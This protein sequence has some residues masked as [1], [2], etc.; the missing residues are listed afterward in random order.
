MVARE[1]AA[2]VFPLISPGSLGLMDDDEEVRY[3]AQIQ[4]TVEAEFERARQQL[5]DLT[6]PSGSQEDH[7]AVLTYLRDIAD[8]ARRITDAAEANDHAALPSLYDESGRPS[9]ALTRALS[10]DGKAVFRPLL[11]EE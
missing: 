8:I 11:F 9:L 5:S 10:E 6:P 2:T 3:L 7:D 4:P 1:T